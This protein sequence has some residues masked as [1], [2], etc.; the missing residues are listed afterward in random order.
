M[1]SASVGF[2]T[3][4]CTSGRPEK[5]AGDD[6]RACVVAILDYFQQITLLVGEQGSGP[7]SSQG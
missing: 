7:E 1:A 4:K 3:S 5:L 6:Q 2:P